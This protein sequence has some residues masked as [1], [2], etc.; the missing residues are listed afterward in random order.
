MILDTRALQRQCLA[1]CIA[2]QRADLT[3]VAYSSVD[4]WLRDQLRYPPLAAVLMNIGG[5]QASEPEMA[6]DIHHVC[7]TLPAPVVVLADSTDVANVACAIECGA[8]GY[9]PQSVSLDI[10]IEAV[11]LA[12]AGGIF[13][14]GDSVFAMRQSLQP[15]TSDTKIFANLFTER[16]IEV[17]EAL[18][19]GKANRT[20]AHELNLRESTVKVHV[21]NIM[22]KLNATNRT[23]VAYKINDYFPGEMTKGDLDD[24]R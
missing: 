22:K 5:M 9:I 23:E 16:Q 6:F 18:R 19:R 24:E 21:R 13:V 10:C 17:I 4:E 8:K 1:D 3:V 14:P 11:A 20:I 12:M 7:V 2:A 15:E